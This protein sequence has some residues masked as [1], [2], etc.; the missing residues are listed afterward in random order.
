MCVH[1]RIHTYSTYIMIQQ[2]HYAV[3]L[4]V[5]RA[6]EIEIQHFTALCVCTYACA[7]TRYIQYHIIYTLQRHTA[8]TEVVV[9]ELLALSTAA[10][11]TLYIAV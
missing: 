7:L 8:T 1:I 5:V 4:H 3:L 11:L 2:Q 9:I 10:C 6:Q